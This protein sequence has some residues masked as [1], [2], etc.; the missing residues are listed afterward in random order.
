MTVLY[1]IPWIPGHCWS[2]N[3]LT[4]EY[5]VSTRE[6]TGFA[7]STALDPGFR[8]CESITVKV[9]EPLTVALGPS[10]RLGWLQTLGLWLWLWLWLCGCGSQKAL[11]TIS[12][13][14]CLFSWFHLLR[15]NLYLPVFWVSIRVPLSTSH[16][17]QFN[18]PPLGGTC[19]L[20]LGTGVLWVWL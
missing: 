10:F 18:P 11:L 2:A 12:H 1:F 14:S 6:D 9:Q 20:G 16:L 7:F 15:L 8:V 4:H 13:A 3:D 5:A 19:G 17:V